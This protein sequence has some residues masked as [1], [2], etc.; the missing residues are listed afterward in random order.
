MATSSYTAVLSEFPPRPRTLPTL[1]AA[2]MLKHPFCM[3]S[4]ALD[5]A[6]AKRF[7]AP[8]E[9]LGSLWDLVKRPKVREP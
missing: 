4:A 5:D 7:E 2:E 1:A 9:T 3:D 8:E 6:V